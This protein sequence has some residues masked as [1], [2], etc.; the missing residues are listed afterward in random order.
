MFRSGDGRSASTARDHTS[1]P[2][3]FMPCVGLLAD[4]MQ[5]E[6]IHIYHEK[7]NDEGNPHPPN[8]LQKPLYH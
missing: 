6:N 1:P 4:P 7:N 8:D 2:C 3:P 5:N